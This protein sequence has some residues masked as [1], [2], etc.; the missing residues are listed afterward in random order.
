LEGVAVAGGV[1]VAV[2]EISAVCTLL[3]A[4]SEIDVGGV[5]AMDRAYVASEMTAFLSAW[6]DGLE[7][8]MINRPTPSCLCGPAWG[9]ERWRY[10][11][12]AAGL[13][14][15]HEGETVVSVVGDHVFGAETSAQRDTAR[16]LARANDVRALRVIL[17]GP[18]EAPSVATAD[19]WLDVDDARIADAA[20][21]LL[22]A[23]P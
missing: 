4:V 11:A 13:R 9:P 17:G 15:V 23:W 10:A 6:L 21:D 22:E 16:T 18:R 5:R 1:T 12:A 14:A 19:L 8:P 20:R 3:P 2:G 7:C